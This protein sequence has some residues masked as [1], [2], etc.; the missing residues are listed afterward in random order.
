MLRVLFFFVQW[1]P[2]FFFKKKGFF[3]F[4]TVEM[5]MKLFRTFTFFFSKGW[6]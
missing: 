4:R 5:F 1:V 2:I 6:F 3:M